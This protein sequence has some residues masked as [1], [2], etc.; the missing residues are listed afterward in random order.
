MNE[1]SSFCDGSWFV[2]LGSIFVD[3]L[4]IHNISAELEQICRIRA[5]LSFCQVIPEILSWV[6][7]HYLIGGDLY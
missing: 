4:L 3:G 2:I 7:S 5:F 6:T 1:A